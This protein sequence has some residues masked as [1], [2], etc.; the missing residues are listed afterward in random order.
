[1]D[2]D[3]ITW[4]HVQTGFQPLRYVTYPGPADQIQFVSP[5]ILERPGQEHLLVVTVT[6][7]AWFAIDK[8]QGFRVA[9]IP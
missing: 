7:G 9:K 4:L 8:H 6:G 1:V 2:L 3:D 5:S